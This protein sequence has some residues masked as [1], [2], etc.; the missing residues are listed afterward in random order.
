MRLA[1]SRWMI[2]VDTEAVAIVA[3]TV[4]APNLSK[5][6]QGNTEIDAAWISNKTGQSLR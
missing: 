4:S 1:T 2:L 3:L 6:Q 5:V